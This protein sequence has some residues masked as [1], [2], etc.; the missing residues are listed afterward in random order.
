M[1]NKKPRKSSL[2][3]FYISEGENLI[4]QKLKL[5]LNDII[6]AQSIA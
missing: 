3:K 6:E 1:K 2:I 4:K 5:D